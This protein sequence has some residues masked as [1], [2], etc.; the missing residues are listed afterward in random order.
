MMNLKKGLFLIFTLTIGLLFFSCY[1]N[2]KIIKKENISN[3]KQKEFRSFNPNKSSKL[4]KR[5]SFNFLQVY[6][7]EVE[8][9]YQSNK[10]RIDRLQEGNGTENNQNNMDYMKELYFLKK[11]N[12]SLKSQ[13]SASKNLKAS[14][15]NLLKT[16]L[17]FEMAEIDQIIKSMEI[18][19][20]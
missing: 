8:K 12:L 18:L 16:T 14:D 11:R 19:Q 20:N 3:N 2:E 10:N 6:I 13:I 9:Q 1:P 5:E 7:I 4:V 17:D 15:L